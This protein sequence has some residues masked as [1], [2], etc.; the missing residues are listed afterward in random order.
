MIPRQLV[1]THIG[2]ACEEI[3]SWRGFDN[4]QDID[5]NFKRYVSHRIKMKAPLEAY[6]AEFTTALHNQLMLPYMVVDDQ[7]NCMWSGENGNKRV[8]ILLNLSRLIK[9]G[10]IK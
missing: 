4:T 10:E 5:E 3:L 7:L 9:T 8:R 1:L 6:M 2:R